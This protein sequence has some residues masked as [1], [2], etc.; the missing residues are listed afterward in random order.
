MQV[1]KII[2]SFK[3]RMQDPEAHISRTPKKSIR[4]LRMVAPL[5]AFKLII[6][7]DEERLRTSLSND[8]VKVVVDSIE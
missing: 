5:S 3:R 7:C 4:E 2:S 1:R 6:C 8:A